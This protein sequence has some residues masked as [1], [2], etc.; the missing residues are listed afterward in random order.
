M[1]KG[2]LLQRDG[3]L[4]RSDST[5]VFA[6]RQRRKAQLPKVP[7]SNASVGSDFKASFRKKMSN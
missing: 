4:A 7:G 1:I 5:A 3:G 2:S 6:S